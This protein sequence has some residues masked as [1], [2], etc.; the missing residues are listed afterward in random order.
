MERLHSAE[1]R[2]AFGPGFAM[3]H[4]R[5]SY[6]ANAMD[7]RSARAALRPGRVGTAIIRVCPE[8]KGIL[9]NL[10]ATGL[11]VLFGFLIND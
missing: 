2:L 10:R 1:F 4:A 6:R 5:R 9:L 7:L 3:H 11:A 8:P